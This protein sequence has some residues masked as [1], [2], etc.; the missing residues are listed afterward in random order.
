MHDV[1]G[2]IDAA[3]TVTFTVYLHNST[4]LQA[5][6]TGTFTASSFSGTYTGPYGSGTWDGTKA[7]LLRS[8]TFH[9]ITNVGTGDWPL[10][11]GPTVTFLSPA[12][13][14]DPNSPTT[15]VAPG[16]AG[17]SLYCIQYPNPPLSGPEYYEYFIAIPDSSEPSGFDLA[18]YRGTIGGFDGGFVG[19][20]TEN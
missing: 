2:T 12:G 20:M 3:G 15:V 17:N 4:A 7:Q 10:T 18:W 9:Q 13:C 1:N 14:N 11:M 6:A 19:L 8:T 16:V 5:T